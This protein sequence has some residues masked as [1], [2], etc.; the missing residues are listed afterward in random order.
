MKKLYFSLL[1]I[2]CAVF[3]TCEAQHYVTIPDTA[4]V[5]W[6]QG[7][8][9]AGCMSGNQLD[10]T[11]NAVV[12]ATIMRC[13]GV[14]IRDLTGIQYFKNLTRLDCS[15][16]SLTFLPALPATLTYLKCQ[17]NKIISL[18]LLPAGLKTL[19]AQS[20][21]LTSLPP[22]PTGLDTL[23]CNLNQLGSLP[24]LPST[25][26]YFVCVH[27]QLTAL[28]ALP[29]PLH[30]LTC[31]DNLLTSI[32]ALPPSLLE[33]GCQNNHLD[34][35]PSPLPATMFLFF[36]SNNQLTSMP[37]LP[38]AVALF[39]CGNNHLTS[40]PPLPFNLT[41]FECS[42]NALT[43]MPALPDYNLEI[44]HCDFN[45]LTSLPPIPEGVYYLSCGH[46]QLNSLP[47]LP[48]TLQ[49]LVCDHNQL[50]SI[51]D[52]HNTNYLEL[53]CRCNPNLYCL[54]YLTNISDL[55]FDSTGITCLPNYSGI[56][57]SYPP[58]DSIPLCG[59]YNSNG[60]TPYWNISGKVFY[61]ANSDCVND[62]G[63]IE[64]NYVKV[65]LYDGNNNLVQQVFTGGEGN[66]SFQTGYDNYTINLDTANIPFIVYCPYTGYL[67]DTISLN[68]SLSYSKNFAV[69]C[70]SQ[71]FDIGVQSI[72]NAG[73]LPRPAAV[74]FL[75]T[76]AGDISELYGAHCA[77]GISGQVQLIYSGQLTYVSPAFGALAPTNVNGDTITWNIADFG[78]V[79][80]FGA[81]NLI[82]Q[83]NSN[84]TP[85]TQACFNVNV[86]S[87]NGD[88][89]PVNNTGNYCFTIVNALDPNEKEVYPSGNTDTSNHWLT[90]T[91]RFQNTGTAPALNIRV[92]D[93]LD[94]HVDP[95]TFQLLAYSA[96]NITQIFGN[97]VVFNFPNINLPD[98]ATSDSASRG[99]VQYK[100]KLKDNLPIGTQIQNT[101]NIYFDLNPAVVTNT[102]VNTIT[103]STG[104]APISNE[105]SMQLYPNPAKNYV[106]VETG[107][108]A[109]DG[110]LQI[111]DVTGRI[112]AKLQVTSYKLQVNTNGFS[113]GVYFV[114]LSDINGRIATRKLVVE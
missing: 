6:L 79:N 28:P 56:Y 40:L 5:T 100:I 106:I 50:T 49:Y 87:T 65:Q 31:E 97:D 10:T 60:C 22:L 74:I 114:K 81:F 71:G 68:D 99:Y 89:N 112:V 75:N 86:T 8:G 13:Y 43:S 37:A 76:V 55:D 66:Y 82:F 61:D 1:L 52:L 34:S 44:V 73:P 92:T 102:T 15:N 35:L 19:I 36:C 77:A 23:Y 84:A 27:N 85:G 88:Y 24:S 4:Y 12:N 64:Q 16:D 58:L 109:I 63:D 101:A 53:Y 113:S 103:T 111:T 69:K 45:Q 91:I 47:A 94:S 78:T 39:D 11:C 108:Y 98:S 41:D 21:K 18:L 33:F 104:I 51:P 14:P 62:S 7:H 20:N 80:N 70:R 72:I 42:N 95:S 57:S 2:A 26:V 17:Y 9:F 32:P 105:L 25:L 107:S 54:P 46:N 83:I 110:I 96:K 67:D 93:T 29:A 3:N 59:I 48:T 30:F 90:Y 38:A